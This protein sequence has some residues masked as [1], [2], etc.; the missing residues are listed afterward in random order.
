MFKI[1]QRLQTFTDDFMCRSAIKCCNHGDAT[2]IVLEVG[3]IET[4]LRGCGRKK[5]HVAYPLSQLEMWDSDGPKRDRNLLDTGEVSEASDPGSNRHSKQ[6]AQD[7]SSR[8]LG[9]R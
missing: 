5:G 3:V 8:R 4:L 2:C 1:A 7:D 6:T 9:D